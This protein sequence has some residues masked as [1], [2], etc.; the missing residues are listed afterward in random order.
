MLSPAP[1]HR[2]ACSVVLWLD[3][4]SHV[5]VVARAYRVSRP[6]V[7]RYLSLWTEFRDVAALDHVVARRLRPWRVKGPSAGRPVV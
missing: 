4:G 2:R 7:Y 1:P 3:R 5:A 6:T